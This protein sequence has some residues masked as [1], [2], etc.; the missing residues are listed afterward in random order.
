MYPLAEVDAY[1]TSYIGIDPRERLNILYISIK[2]YFLSYNMGKDI[3]NNS[4]IC[5]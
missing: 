3:L 4:V 2:Y 5:C 1:I